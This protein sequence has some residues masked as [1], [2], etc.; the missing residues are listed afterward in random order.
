MTTQPKYDVTVNLKL[1]GP[2]GNAFAILGVV[3]RALKRAGVSDADCAAFFEE[4]TAG[5]YYHLL[6]TVRKWVHV[7]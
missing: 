2:G 3:E 1:N 5:D 7:R 6:D 4:A